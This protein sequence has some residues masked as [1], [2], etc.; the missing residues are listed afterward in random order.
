MPSDPLE[1]SKDLALCI[2]IIMFVF[3]FSF[4]K[5]SL[6][7]WS[8]KKAITIQ[9]YGTYDPIP[10]PF[11]LISNFVLLMAYI[12]RKCK[13]KCNLPQKGSST[14]T[15]YDRRVSNTLKLTLF[16]AAFSYG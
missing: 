2:Y 9:S 10:V 14:R 1:D 3:L 8:F 13:E 5:N 12:F 7:E 15:T 16:I 6:M 11:N 4:Q